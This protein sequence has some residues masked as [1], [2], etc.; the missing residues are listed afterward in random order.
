M[1][2]GF[3]GNVAKPEAGKNGE[4]YDGQHRDAGDRHRDRKEWL[5]AVA[6]YERHLEHA[7]YDHA[8]W[9]QLGN[10]AK[11]AGQ[12]GHSLGAYRKAM[13]LSDASSDLHMQLGHLN[14]LRKNRAAALRH[15]EKALALDPDNV[16]AREELRRVREMFVHLPF[17]LETT[18]LDDA[19]FTEVHELIAFSSSPDF[20]EDPF[21][22]FYSLLSES[23]ACQ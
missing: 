6:C 23:S 18:S 2:K 20:V 10:V 5:E 9:I 8:I 12:L 7:P 16:E 1:I 21:A 17:I 15:Y 22:Q 3:L 11:E 19:K 4:R 14:K 13:Q